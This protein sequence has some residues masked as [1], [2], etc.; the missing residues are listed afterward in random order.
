MRS[1]NVIRVVSACFDGQQSSN[2]Q[3]NANHRA[4]GAKPNSARRPYTSFSMLNSSRTQPV[5]G[6]PYSS[7]GFFSFLPSPTPDTVCNEPIY[8]QCCRNAC[9]YLLPILR[10]PSGSIFGVIAENNELGKCLLLAE[11]IKPKYCILST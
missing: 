7:L 2:N 6:G 11:H 9:G 8:L 4:F 5:D 10:G 1:S 3:M